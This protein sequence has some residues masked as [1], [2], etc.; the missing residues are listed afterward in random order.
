[1]MG[2]RNET[3]DPYPSQQYTGVRQ[4]AGPVAPVFYPLYGG[5]TANLFQN[6]DER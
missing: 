3:I 4:A 1:M 6:A 2:K 5:L